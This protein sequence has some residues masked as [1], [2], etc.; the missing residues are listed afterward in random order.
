MKTNSVD[1][2][3]EQRKRWTTHPTK[4]NILIIIGIWL[5]G[6]FLL[7]IASTDFFTESL[8][9]KKHILVYILMTMSTMTTAR[10]TTNYFRNKS[11]D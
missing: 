3:E 6:N 9:N 1:E 10:L 11:A 2:K 8:L 4:K 7:L 5:V